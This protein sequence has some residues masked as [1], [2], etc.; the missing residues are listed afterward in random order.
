M[1]DAHAPE[2][3]NDVPERRF[4]SSGQCGLGCSAVS[5]LRASLGPDR[6][7]EAAAQEP[8][9]GRTMSHRKRRGARLPRFEG[10]I[11]RRDEG[12]IPAA[13]RKR[14]APGGA[15][16]R[17]TP[18]GAGFTPAPRMPR[19]GMHRRS[20]ATV[21]PDPGTSRCGPADGARTC[22]AWCGVC[23]ARCPGRGPS[24]SRSGDVPGNA[25]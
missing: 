21:L 14:G 3:W 19:A 16:R 5:A 7:A 11:A 10:G 15:Q 22:E 20:N 12:R 1:E 23:A 24:A 13:L 4:R 9:S 2:R 18:S 17:G 6:D 25:E 8:W